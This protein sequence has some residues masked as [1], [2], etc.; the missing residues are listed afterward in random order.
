[1]PPRG[2]NRNSDWRSE[3]DYDRS[4]DYPRGRGRDYDRDARSGPPQRGRPQSNWD[5][6][7][8]YAYRRDPPGS[9]YPPM[10]GSP[11]HGRRYPRDDRN[12]DRDY[13]PRDRPFYGRDYHDMPHQPSADY[14][15]EP[16]SVVFVN[17]E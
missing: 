17:W 12:Y 7:P 5:P 10:P 14:R 8:K 3:S 16:P 4:Y 1:M 15:Q 2:G 6:D 9:R 11:D 13:E